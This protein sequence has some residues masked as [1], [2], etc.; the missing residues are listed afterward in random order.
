[1]ELTLAEKATLTAY[2]GTE[3]FKI[4]MRIMEE[5]VLK[6]NTALLNAKKPEDV[7]QAHNLAKA[8]AMFHQGVINRINAA[9]Y[10]YK[11][12]PRDGD[13]PVDMTEGSLMLQDYTE[14]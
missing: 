5:E 14:A 7:L 6:F 12:T 13:A 8:A 2:S 1:M 3:G 10:E 9:G 11:N 4:L